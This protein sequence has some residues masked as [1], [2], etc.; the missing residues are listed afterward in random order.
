MNTFD[1]IEEL[2]RGLQKQSDIQNSM[3]SRVKVYDSI[4]DALRHGH[5]GQIFSTKASKRLYVITRR[6]WGKS[7][8]QTV[9]DKTAKGFSPGS[10]PS[11]F[12]DIKT[13]A[14]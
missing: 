12:K 8:Q 9:G 14:V 7:G 10:I 11:A 2:N 5:Y 1:I 13:Y 4:D 6:K 3:K